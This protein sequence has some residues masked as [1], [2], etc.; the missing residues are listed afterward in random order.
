MLFRSEAGLP[1]Y[2]S[3]KSAVGIG[4]LLLQG[5]GDTIRVSI[6]ADPLEEIRVCKQILKSLHL[7]NKEPEVI[8][9]PTCGR[10]EIDLIKITKEIE[11]RL[12]KL[13][14][15]IKVSVMGCVVNGPGEAREA[16]WGIAGGRKQ[17]AIFRKGKILKWVAEDK[18]VDEFM[19]MVEA[20][21]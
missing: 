17:G 5:I 3:I 14:K 13:G 6:S 10:I 18:L 1:P 21:A 7:F 15:P 19:K 2:G 8:S 9:C 16:D 11:E 20:E 12:M 4:A